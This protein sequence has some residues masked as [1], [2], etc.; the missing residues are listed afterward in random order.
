MDKFREHEDVFHPEGCEPCRKANHEKLGFL[1]SKLHYHLPVLII[2]LHVRISS[3][4]IFNFK[5]L[6]Y[7]ING[8]TDISIQ[9]VSLLLS[10]YRI[11]IRFLFTQ[12][13]VKAVEAGFSNRD[14]YV[15][16]R[17]LY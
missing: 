3:P 12:K 7:V 17:Q 4:Y 10:E 9:I 14:N 16:M 15:I 8:L 1:S 6:Y 13:P 5:C 2:I 11:S